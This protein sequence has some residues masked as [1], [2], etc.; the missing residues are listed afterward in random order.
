M[1]GY[2]VS[3]KISVK[4]S[5][6]SRFIVLFILFALIPACAIGIV[7]TYMNMQTRTSSMVQNDMMIANLVGSQ[8]EQV[9]SDAQGLVVGA[10]GSPTVQ[11]MN[12]AE[13]KRLLLAIQKENAHFE[14]L[15]VLDPQGMQIARTSGSLANRSDRAYFKEA[16]QGKTY[17]TD[18][19]ISYFT[20]SP[21]V[22]ISTPIKNPAGQIVGV[23]GADISLKT[24]WDMTEKT[25][26]GWSGYID[27]V[28]HAGNLVV[29]P[30]KERILQKGNE[31]V[32]NMDYVVKAVSGGAG[33]VEA[34]STTGEES[35]I[36]YT[37]IEKLK[38]GVV[39]YRPKSEI[40]SQMLSSVGTMAGIIIVAVLLAAATAFRV[41]RGVADPLHRLAE[42]AGKMAD[43][44]LTQEVNVSGAQEVDQLSHALTQ[45]Q[46]SLRDISKQIA[47]SADQV[48]ASSEQ[49]TASAE[50]SAQ[51]ANQ[52]A[53]TITE[54]AQGTQ[55]QLEAVNQAVAT[56]EQVSAGIQQVAQ[57]TND[58]SNAAGSTAAAANQ[59]GEAINTA[60]SQMANIEKAV[61]YSADV[62]AKLGQR[63]QE[64]GQIVDTI[65][66]IA[67]QTNLLALNAAIEAARA[68]ELGRGFAVVAEE[69]RK[70]AEQS[71]E[72]AKQIAELIGEV[73]S[74]TDNAITAMNEGTSQVRLGTEVVTNAGRA[75]GD[76]VKHINNISGQVQ[77]ISSEIEQMARGSQ[78]IV[79]AV[80]GID[81][82]SRTTAD[83]TQTVSAATEEQSAAMQEIAASS[84]SLA[85]MADELQKAVGRFKLSV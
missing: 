42:A 1:G 28:D 19:Y 70:L 76:V 83:Q 12:A 67:G 81:G 15:Y 85:K 21:T 59:G 78:Q 49:L 72:A 84:Q 52:V 31:N 47:S 80:R 75:F 9:M 8:I 64:I 24:L 41:A 53:T 61:T 71:Q 14:L 32:G 6:K 68:G 30:D 5:L 62:V 4:G 43:G 16:M 23:L 3:E 11:S 25:K 44:D 40:R 73:R 54:V 69:V 33:S 66:G 29:H 13:I 50:Q 51:A 22:T 55:N 74:D 58:V 36:V 39:T 82:I 56:V 79:T 48:A 20:N 7:N 57:K 60:M 10:A 18:T 45:M 63:S 46:A 26:V 27:V 38:W 35:L 77:E 65:S 2:K 37:P 17:F 34:L